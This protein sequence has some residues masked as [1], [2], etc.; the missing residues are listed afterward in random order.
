[1]RWKV[2]FFGVSDEE[3]SCRGG[4]AKGRHRVKLAHQLMCATRDRRRPVRT[5]RIR[6]QWQGR[7][8]GQGSPEISMRKYEKLPPF[9]GSLSPSRP[10]WASLIRRASP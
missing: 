7:R 5:P 8:Q 4:H 1:M 9:V 2:E 6:W 3:N 10:R